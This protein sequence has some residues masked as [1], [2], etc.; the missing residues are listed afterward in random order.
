MQETKTIDHFSKTYANSVRGAVI[1]HGPSA[2]VPTSPIIAVLVWRSANT[3]TGSMAQVFILP[4]DQSP[5]DSL[6]TADANE[7]I[8][9]TC[10][11]QGRYDPVAKKRRGRSCYVRVYQSPLAV[12]RAWERG[13]YPE[14]H[15][16][17]CRHSGHRRRT[18]A[19]CKVFA[20]KLRVGKTRIGSYGDPAALPVALVRSLAISSAGHTAYSSSLFSIPRRRA[21]ALAKYCMCSTHSEDER[22]RAIRRGW[23]T[24]HVVPLGDA[25]P[26]TD[27]IECLHYS[28]RKLTC[29]ECLLCEGAGANLLGASMHQGPH[30]WARAHGFAKQLIT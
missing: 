7:A 13:I 30:I 3:K 4:A 21:D 18:C 10:V 17:I 12:F 22:R 19:R 27:T 24:F 23:R 6:N 11:L 26:T 1:Y 2:L 5:L 15:G 8:C 25:P 16:L 20:D 29:A 14:W 9:G 28:P